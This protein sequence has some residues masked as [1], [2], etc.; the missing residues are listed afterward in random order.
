MVKHSQGIRSE[1]PKDSQIFRGERVY[2]IV[3]K[4]MYY[5]RAN[6]AIIDCTAVFDL[7]SSA[8]FHRLRV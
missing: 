1:K 3:E 6:A 7:S 8:G 4:T 5:R 2:G